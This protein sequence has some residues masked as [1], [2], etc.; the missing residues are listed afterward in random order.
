MSLSENRCIADKEY[1][2]V[3]SLFIYCP[4]S[5]VLLYCTA[6]SW[7]SYWHASTGTCTTLCTPTTTLTPRATLNTDTPRRREWV[8]LS[9]EWAQVCSIT[10]TVYLETLYTHSSI[11][12]NA[13]HC[14]CSLEFIPSYFWLPFVYDYT[15]SIIS[16][17]ARENVLWSTYCHAHCLPSLQLSLNSTTVVSPATQTQI[18]IPKVYKD[19]LDIFSKA[20]AAG[21]LHYLIA[22]MPAP[23]ISYQEFGHLRVK[24]APCHCISERP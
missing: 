8:C 10:H 2:F 17:N 18:Q 14:H 11:E 15:V 6:F 23:L 7:F 3:I 13:K 9:T 24:F 16:L 5:K 20:K 21:L 1:F 19:F 12:S 4:Y 22:V